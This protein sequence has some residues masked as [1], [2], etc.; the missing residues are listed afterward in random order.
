MPFLNADSIAVATRG[1]AGSAG[2]ISAAKL[3]LSQLDEALSSGQ[4]VSC[5]TTLSGLVWRCVIA[6]ARELGYRIVVV[7]VSVSSVELSLERIEERARRGGH[8]IPPDTVRRRWP[9]SHNNF[10]DTYQPLADQWYLF[11]NS[12]QG[13][14]LVAEGGLRDR[15]YNAALLEEMKLRAKKS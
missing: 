5:E 3:M 10:F 13:A 8:W 14:V 6:Q 9:R 11:D 15:I 2:E 7:F 1:V 12:K 4:S